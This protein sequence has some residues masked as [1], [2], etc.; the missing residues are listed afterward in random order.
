[1]VA[2]LGKSQAADLHK[3]YSSLKGL[4]KAVRPDSLNPKSLGRA[5]LYGISRTAEV[6]REHNSTLV[7]RSDRSLVAQ[8]V[9]T[10]PLL[11]TIHR[12]TT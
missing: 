1:V 8:L 4:A 9:L 11:S 3:D 5:V 7:V 2:L 12:M 10:C 6:L